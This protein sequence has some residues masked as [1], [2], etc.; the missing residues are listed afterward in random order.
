MPKSG[1]AKTMHD[2]KTTYEKNAQAQMAYAKMTYAQMAYVTSD[3]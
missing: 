2:M 3:M 1:Y